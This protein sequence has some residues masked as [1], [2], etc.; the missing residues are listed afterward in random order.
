[1]RHLSTSIFRALCRFFSRRSHGMLAQCGAL[2]WREND[3]RKEVLLITSREAG[4]WIIPK[5]WPMNG[6]TLAEAAAQE[7]WEEAGIRGTAHPVSIGRYRY[8]KRAGS[9]SAAEV[10]VTVFSLEALQE[11]GAFPEQ[12]QRDKMWLPPG[13]AA[14]TVDNPSLRKLIASFA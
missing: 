1:M 5:G 12:G 13:E 2:C 10:E 6:K 8:V 3:G 11:K 9:A 4:R 14:D 7:A